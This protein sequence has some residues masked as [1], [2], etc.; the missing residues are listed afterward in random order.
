MSVFIIL[1]PGSK[2]QRH[3]ILGE[4]SLCLKFFLHSN[5]AHQCYVSL[6]SLLHITGA[7]STNNL[8]QLVWGRTIA[9][10]DFTSG[11]HS[12]ISI[13]ISQLLYNFYGL[14]LPRQS[15][16]KIYYCTIFLVRINSH[17]VWMKV[18]PFLQAYK[19]LAF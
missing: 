11:W 7:C 16:Y 13:L 14:E 15:I 17:C 8:A 6:M 10:T 3:R 1:S 12:Y 4:F 5:S 2:F 9:D 19:I 18:P